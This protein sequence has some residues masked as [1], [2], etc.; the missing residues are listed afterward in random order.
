M[1]ETS[2]QLIQV[3]EEKNGFVAAMKI[4]NN[5]VR[6]AIADLQTDA[7]QLLIYKVKG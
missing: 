4:G 7:V 3:R 5:R 6:Y 1:Q 2:V